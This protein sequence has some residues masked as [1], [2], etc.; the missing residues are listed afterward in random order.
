MLNKNIKYN[1]V[2]L[3]IFWKGQK[4]IQQLPKGNLEL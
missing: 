1:I 2:I 3:I 4:L